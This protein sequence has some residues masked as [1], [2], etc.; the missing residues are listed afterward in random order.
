MPTTTIPEVTTYNTLAE[1]AQIIRGANGSE[2]FAVELT[3]AARA[4]SALFD[5]ALQNAAT[6]TFTALFGEVKYTV[7]ALADA[8]KADAEANGTKAVGKTQ[9]QK[10]AEAGR[11]FSLKGGWNPAGDTPETVKAARVRTLIEQAYNATKGITK[12]RAAIVGTQGEAIKAL[13]ALIE[14]AAVI[15]EDDDDA[16]TEAPVAEAEEAVSFDDTL[17]ALKQ[18]VD[19]AFA[20][21][22]EESTKEQVQ[23]IYTLVAD[24][25]L[26]AQQVG[27]LSAVK[28]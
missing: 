21:L 26:L 3:D 11:F 9:L 16:T 27:E 4:A 20:A 12:V 6:A 25:Q 24:I 13:K 15:E 28:V 2:A 22:P 7:Q 10:Y 18:A 17:A 14:D 5:I 8:V 19:A 1:V 23:D